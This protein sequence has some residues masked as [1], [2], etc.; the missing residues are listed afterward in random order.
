MNRG[1]PHRPSRRIS[2]ILNETEI[3]KQRFIVYFPVDYLFIF[4]Y[5]YFKI[6]KR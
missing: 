4:L 5:K 3:K 1:Y 2:D 6:K